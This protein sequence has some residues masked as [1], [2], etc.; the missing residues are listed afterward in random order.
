MK[1]FWKDKSI[2][3]KKLTQVIEVLQTFF[4]LV[5]RDVNIF[6]FDTIFIL[7]NSQNYLLIKFKI[8]TIVFLDLNLKLAYY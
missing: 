6:S 3:Y 5:I 2:I 7:K 8:K 4:Y 1:K